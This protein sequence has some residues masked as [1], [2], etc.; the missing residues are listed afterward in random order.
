MNATTTPARRLPHRVA[1]AAAMTA[2]T[3]HD[4]MVAW[5]ASVTARAEAQARWKAAEKAYDVNNVGTRAATVDALIDAID[6]HN[7]HTARRTCVPARRAVLDAYAAAGF[8]QARLVLKRI[9]PGSLDWTPA[10]EA[11]LGGLLSAPAR[12]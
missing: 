12:P 3:P 6:N 10:L 5:G 7:A 11:V 4:A 8:P 2:L 9:A 1:M